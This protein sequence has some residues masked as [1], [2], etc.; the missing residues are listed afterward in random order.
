MPDQIQAVFFDMDGTLLNTLD[1]IC[2]SIRETLAEWGL[3]TRSNAELLPFI[4]YG[5]RHLCQ[6][7]T[8]LTDPERLEAFHRQYRAHSLNRDDPKTVAYSGIPEVVMALRERG[9]KVGICTN[10]PQAWTEKLAASY[11]AEGAFDAIYGVHDGGVIKPEPGGLL[12]MCAEFGISPQHAVMIG[13]SPVDVE[14]GRNA[15]M[16]TLAVTWGFREKAQL[17]KADPDVM[18][19][20]V[21]DIINVIERGF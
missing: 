16:H 21:E 18:I 3:P 8:G 2:G 12:E 13:D 11:F 7:A 19:D 5:A 14:T 9:L 1:D 15:G 20:R 17:V 10:K 4:G 6:G